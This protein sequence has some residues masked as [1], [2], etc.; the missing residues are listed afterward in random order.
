MYDGNH[1]TGWVRSFSYGDFNCC[2][3]IPNDQLSSLRVLEGCTVTVYQHGGYGGWSAHFGPGDYDKNAF[4]A[5]GGRNNDASS[6][7]VR[8]SLT[9]P[10]R[11]VFYKTAADSDFEYH[12]TWGSPDANGLWGP[13]NWNCAV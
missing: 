11:D 8:G 10:D 12:F 5:A 6:L 9:K 7:K 13:P 2:S 3:S 4:V 1:F